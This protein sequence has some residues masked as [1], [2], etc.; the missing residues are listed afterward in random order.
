MF[1]GEFDKHSALRYNS[2]NPVQ[3]KIIMVGPLALLI[4]G[5]AAELPLNKLSK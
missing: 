2:L 3:I 1:D 5:N 4:D